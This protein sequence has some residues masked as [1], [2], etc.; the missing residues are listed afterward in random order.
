MEDVAKLNLGTNT[1]RLKILENPCRLEQS[2]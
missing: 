1:S 2:G